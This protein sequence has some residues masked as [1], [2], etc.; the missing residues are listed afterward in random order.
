MWLNASSLVATFLFFLEAYHAIGHAAVMFRIRMLP[1][2]DLVRVRYYFLFDTLTVF[3]TAFCY[4]GKLRWL[5]ILQ[6]CQ[7]LYF[8]FT[9]NISWYT[10]RVIS[11]SSLDWLHSDNAKNRTEW[12]LFLGT[13]FDLAVHIIHCYILS[14]Y[15]SNI[16]TLAGIFCAQV[17]SYAVI[18]SPSFA[19]SGPRTMPAWIR[20]R[21]A[22]IPDF[23]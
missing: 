19:W 7:H 21:I 6:M 10:R 22:R 2:K 8:F 12:D 14:Q 13:A 9:W 5:A 23:N 3:V 17:V 11:W 4:T 18:F 20:K 1:R 15:M 16:E